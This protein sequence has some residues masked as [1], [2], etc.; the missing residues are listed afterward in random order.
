MENKCISVIIPV[1]NGQEFI[2]RCLTSML[3]QKDLTEIIVVDDGSTDESVAIIKSFTNKDSRIRLLQHKDKSNHGRSAARNLGIR[4][5]SCNWIT[6]C[7]IDD[8]YLPNRFEYFLSLNLKNIDGTHEAVVAD[9]KNESLNSTTSTIT[10]VAQ[11]FDQPK[12]LQN[13]L[14]SN[15]E[16]RI[17]II[18]LIIRKSKIVE[19][20]F[21]DEDLKIGED[22]DMLWRLAGISKLRHIQVVPPRVIRAVHDQNTYQYQDKVDSA[23]RQF[24]EKWMNEMKKYNLS[25]AATNRITK[26]YHHYK[27]RTLSKF[28]TRLIR[29]LKD[30]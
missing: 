29:I 6:F 18:S 14:I 25:P 30:I 28:K 20:G 17:S 9:Y 15:R 10:T 23:R 2:D 27:G 1:Y 7:D 26:S 8:Y 13:F 16:D 5:A 21:F 4:K 11:D 19:A 12:S 24:Y 3:V 22:T